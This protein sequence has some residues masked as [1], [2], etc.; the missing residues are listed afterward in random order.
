MK[1]HETSSKTFR[2]SSHSK[3]RKGPSVAATAFADVSP[4]FLRS[5]EIDTSVFSAQAFREHSF[6]RHTST[7]TPAGGGRRR[8]GASEVVCAQLARGRRGG[9]EPRRQGVGG[10]CRLIRRFTHA[11]IRGESGRAGS[12]RFTMNPVGL[13]LASA[14]RHRTRCS[15]TPRRFRRG[16]VSATS[17][18]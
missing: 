3:I 6:L 4:C 10:T 9:G 7:P 11:T 13:I 12:E 1:A 5:S 15:I 16:A 8:G 17:A 18:Y 2:S 14:A